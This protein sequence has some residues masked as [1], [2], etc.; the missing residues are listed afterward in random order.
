VETALLLPMAAWFLASEA[1]AGAPR[2]A[3][4]LTA[5]AL[6][7]LVTAVPLLCFAAAAARMPLSILGLFQYLAPSLTMVLAVGVYGEPFRPGQWLT[8]GSIW[9]ALLL[10]SA[11]GLWWQRLRRLPG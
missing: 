5:L 7:G 9:A 4:N 1:G 8:F 10:L 11:E 3:W 2:S 6:G